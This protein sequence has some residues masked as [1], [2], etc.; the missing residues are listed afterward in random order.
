MTLA[1]LDIEMVRDVVV[2]HVDGE[3]DMSN[4]NELGEALSRQMSNEALALVIDLTD[5]IY[6]DSAA[7]QVIFS[8][9]ER[10][11]T[12]GQQIR[13]VV[14][15]TSPITDALRIAGVPGAVGVHETRDAALR[16]LGE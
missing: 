14:A 8:L 15:P 3:I 4:A 7:I 5:V 13:L 16:D 1:D 11:R 9:R 2:A 6:L 12:R 10:L